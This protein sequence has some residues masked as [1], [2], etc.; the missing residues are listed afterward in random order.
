M[1]LS[2]FLSAESGTNRECVGAE[3][4]AAAET[5]LPVGLSKTLPARCHIIV[6]GDFN[7]S[8]PRE[9]KMSAFGVLDSE[10]TDQEKEDQG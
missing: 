7:T 8:L 9:S 10:L 1:V 2:V 5:R 6:A 3:A 4:R